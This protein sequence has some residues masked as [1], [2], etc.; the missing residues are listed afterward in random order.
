MEE[1]GGYG[2]VAATACLK[3]YARTVVLHASPMW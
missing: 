1:G 2:S 3:S